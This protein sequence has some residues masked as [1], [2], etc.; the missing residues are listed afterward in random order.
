M[1]RKRGIFLIKAMLKKRNFVN[2][3][4]HLFTSVNEDGQEKV[5]KGNIIRRNTV[6]I[7]FMDVT[8]DSDEE[9]I[10]KGE[11]IINGLY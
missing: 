5:N 2:N 4:M 7:N 1:R 3:V 6:N 10:K 8:S 11:S 9:G